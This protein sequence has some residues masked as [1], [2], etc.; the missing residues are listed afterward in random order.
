MSQEIDELL[1]EFQIV[2]LFVIVYVMEKY[3]VLISCENVSFAQNLF[4]PKVFFISIGYL[5]KNSFEGK[6]SGYKWYQI[7]VCQEL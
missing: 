3:F 5:F 6:L 2:L 4:W 1:F 7:R